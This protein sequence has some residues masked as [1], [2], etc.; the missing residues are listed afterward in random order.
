MI[1]V[2]LAVLGLVFGSFVNAFVWRLHEQEVLRGKKK[3]PSKKQLKKLSILKGRSM[4]PHCKHE[5]RASDL[6]P[7]FSWLSLRGKCRY[8]HKPISAQYPV[9]EATTAV[10]FALS[11]VWWPLSLHGVGLVQLIFWLGF[12]IMFVA[13]AVY[14]IKWFLLPN[15]V[16]YPLI[17]L[18]TVEVLVVAITN[19]APHTLLDAGLGAL[20]ISG[21]FY[22][23]FQ[24][25]GGAWIGGG[26]V[27]L[28][29]VLGLLAATP[30]KALLIIFFASVVGTI[31]SIPMLLKGKKGLQMRVPF[32]PFLL[33]A[34]AIVVLFGD[35]VVHWYTRTLLGA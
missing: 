18:A 33:V 6:V 1:I 20:V 9:V 8:C 13:L 3:Q 23:L 35:S 19:H 5:L 27:K 26:D 30:L 17:G 22:I 11:Y 10:L 14:D 31:C 24:V 2:L 25:S 32:G 16:V 28:A 29:V 21:V 12:V 7:L 34:T 15:K 4:C